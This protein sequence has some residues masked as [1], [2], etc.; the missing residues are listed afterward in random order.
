MF[1]VVGFVVVVVF[2][3]L[4]LRSG[5]SFLGGLFF[6]FFLLFKYTLIHCYYKM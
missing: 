2:F 4:F 3:G 5:G 6:V 1:F